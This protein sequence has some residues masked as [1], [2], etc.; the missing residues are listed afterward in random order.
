MFREAIKAVAKNT[1]IMFFQQIVT[2]G[3]AFL[4]MLFV[5]RY[6]GPVE[7]GK[8]FLATAITNVFR[9]V[10]DYGGS[11]MVTKN[12]SRSLEDT[13]Q[14]LSDAIGIRIVLGIIS[15]IALIVFSYVVE[16]SAEV[17]LVLVIFGVSLMWRGGAVVLYAGYQGHER[18]QYTSA[19]TI[20]ESLF[21]GL[22]S[23]SAVLLGTGV[24]VIA[25]VAL[26]SNLL[27]FVVLAGYAK[28]IIRSLPRVNWSGSI[29]HIKEGAVYF[30]FVIFGAIY[31]RI[32]T[33]MLSKMAP[34]AVVGW[35][36]GAARLFEALNFLPFIFTTA[37]YP[38]LSR[39]WTERNDA[40]KRTAQR[41]LEF[42]IICGIPI[43]VGV[44]AFAEIIIHLF[45]GSKYEASVIVFQVLSTGLILLYVD[46]VLGTTL[47]ASDKQKQLS[48]LSLSAI[49]INVVLNFV[50]VPYYQMH[51]ENGAVGGAI[52]TVLTELYMFIV[53]LHLIPKGVLKGFRFEIM[54][55]AV[56]AGLA[57]A[58]SIWLMHSFGIPILLQAVF[59]PAVYLICLILMNPFE[60]SEVA[61]L[62]EMLTLRKLKTLNPFVGLVKDGIVKDQL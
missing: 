5:P 37:V 8:L 7:Y 4:V 53:A 29:R 28:R 47:L 17:R 39:M 27:N 25:L 23:V 26:V 10:V 49:P 54:A 58:A 16:Y 19:A 40:H 18:M 35:Y 20:A 24:V 45:Y 21:M 55:K 12:V 15:F 6:L 30:L 38:V 52:T 59:S 31:Y 46:M 44:I 33:V 42:M 60:A 57:M 36:G 14:I 1:S 50:L 34:E 2:W 62:K 41:S 3:S 61:F 56:L 32:V 9:T 51:M 22:V 43:S 13:P 11:Y 48:L